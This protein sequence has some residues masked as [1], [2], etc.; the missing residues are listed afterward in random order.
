MASAT[1]SSATPTARSSPASPCSP[2]RMSCWACCSGGCSPSATSS[3]RDGGKDD[4]GLDPAGAAA[5]RADQLDR[6]RRPLSPGDLAA[7]EGLSGHL[8]GPA[9]ANLIFMLILTVTSGGR[10]TT[11]GGLNLADFIAPGL[12]MFAAGE[13][14]FS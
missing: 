11:I 13:R 4:G 2:G 7:A 3:G 12:I 6:Y 5:F 10:A 1:A 14:A 8:L 9:L